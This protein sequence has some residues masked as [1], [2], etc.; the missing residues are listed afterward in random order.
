MEET[1]INRYNILE[2]LAKLSSY[3][4]LYYEIEEIKDGKITKIKNVKIDS[5]DLTKPV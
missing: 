3:K 4:N 2:L 1:N 5:I